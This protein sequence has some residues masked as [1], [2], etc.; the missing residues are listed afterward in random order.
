MLSHTVVSDKVMWWFERV[1][2]PQKIALS[3][4]VKIQFLFYVISGK[5]H[6]NQGEKKMFATINVS[7]L[8]D[9]QFKVGMRYQHIKAREEN[10]ISR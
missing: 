4:P 8:K 5:W 9:K 6:K 2:P 7:V 1:Q 3:S 10:K